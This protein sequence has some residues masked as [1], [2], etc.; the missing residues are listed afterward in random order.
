MS[1]IIQE[2]RLQTALIQ[3][4]RRCRNTVGSPIRP[5]ADPPLADPPIRFCPRPYAD[6]PIRFRLRPIIEEA[7]RRRLAPYADPPL[8]DPPIRFCWLEAHSYA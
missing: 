8:A 5:Y 1:E 3:R 4:N 2:K 6:P 7:K